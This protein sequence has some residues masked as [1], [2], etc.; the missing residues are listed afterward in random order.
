MYKMRIAEKG[1]KPNGERAKTTAVVQGLMVE[2]WKYDDE[3][4][5][6]VFG[7]EVSSDVPRRETHSCTGGASRSACR[8]GYVSEWTTR[9]T[10]LPL[11]L[12]AGSSID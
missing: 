3:N 8:F 1:N 12:M 6:F 2:T 11:S 5:V 7:N 9:G 10:A 4:Y